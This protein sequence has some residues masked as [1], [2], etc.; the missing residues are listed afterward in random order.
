MQT[1]VV[2][3]GEGHI[4]SHVIEQLAA[5]IENIK[6]I[7]VDN[8]FN[9]SEDNQVISTKVEYRRGHTKN[10]TDL[11]PERPD[12]VYHL[13]EFARIAPSLKC[14]EKV[15]DLNIVG[16]KSV[17]DYCRKSG[18][19]LVYAASSTRFAVD[20]KDNP[21]TQSKIHNVELI[22]NTPSLNYAIVYFYNAF[23]EREKGE[24]GEEMGTL[25]ARYQG[26]YKRGEA[27]P[28]D[29]PGTQ[30]RNFTHAG[31]LARGMI[32]VGEKG[33]GDGWVLNN[34]NAYSI[35]EIAEAFGGPIVLR[36]DYSGR[37][38]SGSVQEKT[39]EEL[40][41]KTTIDIIDWIKDF[42]AR[43]SQPE[44]EIVRQQIMSFSGV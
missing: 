3:G 38:A 8:L 33:E 43:N 24:H 31:D 30:K 26:F 23:G 7:S 5:K 27:F 44:P 6:I 28:V 36:G 4:G 35:V 21:Y 42:K 15:Y 34:P 39:R 16:T 25:I 10:I 17:V 9:G 18:A 2:T 40:G 22:N 12:M 14:P 32:L 11:V 29:R 1:I 13:G 41:W 20:G 19:K 37:S